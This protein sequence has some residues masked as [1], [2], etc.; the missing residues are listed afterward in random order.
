MEI[1][2]RGL[3]R[4]ETYEAS[5]VE[6]STGNGERWVR[7]LRC[8]SCDATWLEYQ[9]DKRERPDLRACSHCAHLTWLKENGGVLH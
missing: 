7:R 4:Q 1:E 2:Y 8:V 3:I 9:Y 5:R 6:R